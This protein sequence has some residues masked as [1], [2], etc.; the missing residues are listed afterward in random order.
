MKCKLLKKAEKSFHERFS[1]KHKIYNTE[2]N[3]TCMH[4]EL[5]CVCVNKYAHTLKTYPTSSS[6]E[7][8]QE[9]YTKQGLD[10][11]CEGT[12]QT[13]NRQTQNIMMHSLS[14]PI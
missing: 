10:K 14:L 3:V 8:F 9:G 4:N 6:M 2:T 13:G 11:T 1:L 7:N 5:R 12:L